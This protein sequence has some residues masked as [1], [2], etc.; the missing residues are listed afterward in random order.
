MDD[1]KPV[2]PKR[3]EKGEVPPCTVG[4]YF[5]LLDVNNELRYCCRGDKRHDK[6][7]SVASQ[8]NDDKYNQFRKDWSERY[9]T[10]QS[11][12]T[13]CPH[14]EGNIA[15]GKV[16]KDYLKQHSEEQS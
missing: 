11:L 16:I 4:F 6:A 7:V 8:W 3:W 13:G 9:K 14:Q 15:W 12:C 5:T 10:Q 2:Q 1:S